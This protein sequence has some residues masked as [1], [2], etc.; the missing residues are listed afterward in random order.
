MKL[1]FSS[2]QRGNCQNQALQPVQ[3]LIQ[4]LERK[5]VYVIYFNKKNL[6]VQCQ[7]FFSFS[8]SVLGFFEELLL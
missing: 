5:E 1:I 6:E 8:K 2:T 7:C 3:R 4:K